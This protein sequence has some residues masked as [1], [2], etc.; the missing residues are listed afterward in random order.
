[1]TPAQIGQVADKLGALREAIRL[2]Q[3]QE[4]ELRAALLACGCLAAK[5]ANY[6]AFVRRVA[7]TRP[8]IE[9][10][11]SEMGEEWISERSSTKIH[12]RIDIESLH[13]P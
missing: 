8:D 4:S 2:L 11:R 12:L 5:G 1:M 9:R 13:A 3:N 6:C 7:Q 10:I